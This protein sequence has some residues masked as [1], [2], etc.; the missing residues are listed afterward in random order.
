MLWM[1]VSHAARTIF[2]ILPCTK[3][4]D[5]RKG[6]STIQI[7]DRELTMISYCQYIRL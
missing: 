3:E 7:R 2:I 1:P 4:D 6:I 5:A